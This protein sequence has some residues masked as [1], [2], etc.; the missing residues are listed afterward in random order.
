MGT[1]RKLNR[2][3]QRMTCFFYILCAFFICSCGGNKTANKE[4]KTPLAAEL[5]KDEVRY[6]KSIQLTSPGKD[7]MYAF[8][9]E[10]VIG[11]ESKDRFPVDSAAFY[12]DGQ[13]IATA[14]KEDRSFTYR[15]PEGKTGNMTIKVMAWHPDNKRGIATTTIRVKPD[16]APAIYSYEVVNVFPHDPKAYTQGL[17]YQDGFMY[18]GTGQYGESSIRKTDMQ[19]GKLYRS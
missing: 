4:K 15:I 6:V 5:P 13:Q 12:I 2:Y 17:I 8:N 14:G 7:K 10:I 18:E 19:T 3:E 16:Q 9:E 1:G 11:F